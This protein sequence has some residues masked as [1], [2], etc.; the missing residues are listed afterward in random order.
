MLRKSP[1]RPT[2]GTQIHDGY[3]DAEDLPVERFDRDAKLN[4]TY[5][6]SS[7]ILHNTTADQLGGRLLRGSKRSNP[8]RTL[9]EV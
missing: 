5:G 4:E 9:P 3:G 8:L 1:A 6:K 7:E 2:E